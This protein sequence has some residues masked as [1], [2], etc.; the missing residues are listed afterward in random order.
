MEYSGIWSCKVDIQSWLG[1]YLVTK[2]EFRPVRAS[3]I[4]WSVIHDVCVSFGLKRGNST[5]VGW[6]GRDVFRFTSMLVEQEQQQWQDVYFCTWLGRGQPV[7]YF[8][9]IF[10]FYLDQRSLTHFHLF[11]YKFINYF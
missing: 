5:V 2:D 1:Y 8:S 10:Q 7:R 3:L 11:I 6:Q 9:S 4:T